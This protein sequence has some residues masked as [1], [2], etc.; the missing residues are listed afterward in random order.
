[1]IYLSRAVVIQYNAISAISGFGKPH[2]K[3]NGSDTDKPDH[4]DA[5]CWKCRNKG[6][7][8]MNCHLKKKMEKTESGKGKD[9]VNTATCGE[10]FTFTTTFTGA[11]LTHVSNP[12][13]RVE[14]NV[15][16]SD[17]FSH[18]SPAHDQFTTFMAI[19][20]KP[21][22]AANQTLF[23]AKAM[24]KLWVS[25]PSGK[26]TTTNHPQGCSVLP[27]PCVHTCLTDMT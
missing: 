8:R 9:T 19:T 7:I 14:T 22:K 13:A 6:H 17:T 5:E 3:G 16:N 18:M 25:I 21:I 1:M 15:N 10:E 24:G 2:N 12:L 4:T 11:T 27:G 26:S 20:P 23:V